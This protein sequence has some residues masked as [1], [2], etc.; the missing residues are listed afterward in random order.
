MNRRAKVIIAAILTPILC[1]AAPC[2]SG[3][4][5]RSG[6]G[7]GGFPAPVEKPKV[8]RATCPD[9]TF[10]ADD[11]RCLTIQTFVST[12]NGPYD[13]YINIEGGNGAYPPHI[14]I[15]AGGWKHDL[16][17]RT[18]VKMHLK[19]TLSY[20]GR[21]D[22]EGYCSITDGKQYN[23]DSLRSI[24]AGGGSPYQAVCQL[25]TNQ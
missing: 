18:G 5:P 23:K 22:K 2:E 12:R 16:V 17:Y 25:T 8:E 14:P 11:E 19:V 24:T 1:A 3:G 4:D 20:E 10:R 9:T 21:P 13:V 15:A 7:D 6:G